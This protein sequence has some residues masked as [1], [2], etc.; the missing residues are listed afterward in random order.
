M[1]IVS[2]VIL[3]SCILINKKYV[4]MNIYVYIGVHFYV[5]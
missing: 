5:N 2:F 4:N 3:Y 1:F